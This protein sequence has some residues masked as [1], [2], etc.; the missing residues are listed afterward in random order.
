[1]PAAAFALLAFFV[2]VSLV[3]GLLAWWLIGPRRPWGAVLPTL[4][5][6]GALYL[7]GHLL[8][9][10]PGPTVDL[11]GFDVAILFDVGLALLVA[12]C[13]ALLQRLAVR[14]TP[15]EGAARR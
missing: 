14:V 12:V 10:S 15:G 6:F 2:G 8:E 9:I 5:A 13:V 7:F 3:A 4:G 11:F 1:M